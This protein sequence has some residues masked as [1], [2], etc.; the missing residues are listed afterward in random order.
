MIIQYIV[1]PNIGI[2]T[3]IVVISNIIWISRHLVRFREIYIKIIKWVF[4]ISWVDAALCAGAVLA[5]RFT[6][7]GRNSLS[8]SVAV[9]IVFAILCITKYYL[10]T[11]SNAEGEKIY[12]RIHVL[13]NFGVMTMALVI[14]IIAYANIYIKLKLISNGHEVNPDMLTAMYFSVV[15]WTTLGYGDLTPTDAARM[16]AALEATTG[17]VAFTVL[18]SGLFNLIR[19]LNDIKEKR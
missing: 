10:L 12:L 13:A 7:I 3:F 5:M 17:Y 16:Y 4:E 18:T 9:I 6:A 14:M 11:F 1:G 8:F 2:A 15:T 19:R